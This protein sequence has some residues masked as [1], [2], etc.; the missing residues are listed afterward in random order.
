MENKFNFCPICA[1]QN[2]VNVNNRKWECADCGFVFY[3]NSATAVGVIIQNKQGQVLLEV[4]TK[5]PQKGLLDVPG[6]FVEH[7]ESTEQ[8]CIREC[9]EELGVDIK[10]LKYLCCFPNTYEYKGFEYKTCDAF[11]IAE[12]ADNANFDLEADEVADVKW[13]SLENERDL[14]NLP[15]AFDS[16]RKALDFWIKNK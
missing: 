7:D 8:A 5:E 9:R 16:A 11:F 4:R 15:L 14:L 3:N 10:N 13:C 1:G 2:I 6:G 12:I